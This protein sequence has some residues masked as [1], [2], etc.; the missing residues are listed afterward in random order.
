M[1][2]GNGFLDLENKNLKLAGRQDTSDPGTHFSL[3]HT[4]AGGY[5]MGKKEIGTY[6]PKLTNVYGLFGNCL[7]QVRP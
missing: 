2:S 5:G 1:D 7:G 4:P 6:I 3:I